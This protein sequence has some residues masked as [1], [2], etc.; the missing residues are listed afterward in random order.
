MLPVIPVQ[1]RSTEIRRIVLKR[2]NL[3]QMHF[4]ETI[5]GCNQSQKNTSSRVVVIQGNLARAEAQIF[6][7]RIG[8]LTIEA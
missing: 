8:L 1:F 4:R 5:L 7:S 2:V 6:P 3:G